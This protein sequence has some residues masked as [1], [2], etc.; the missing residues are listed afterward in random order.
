MK[1][2]GKIF[3]VLLT[4]LL[5]TGCVKESIHMNIKKNGDVELSLIMAFADSAASYMGDMDELK[6][7]YTEKGY[8]VEDYVE[9]DM[10]G[11]KVTRTYKIDDVSSDKEVTV[12]LGEFLEEPNDK[13]VFFQKSG[14]NYKANFT[15]D[16]RSE[17]LDSSSAS[18]YSANIDISYS[19]TL[20]SKPKSH[21]ATKVDGNTLTWD[22]KYGELTKVNYE[23]SL[24]GSNV[25]WIIIAI[26]G[27][28][29]VAI[30]IVVVV[31]GRK[32]KQNPMDG[33][34]MQQQPFDPVY[35]NTMQ[36][37]AVSPTM[38]VSPMPSSEPVMD[39]V[40][41]A[42]TPSVIETSAM[43]MP[44]PEVVEPV[45]ANTTVVETPVEEVPVSSSEPMMDVTPVVENSTV[46]EIVQE[47][48]VETPLVEEV[49][50]TP[51][52]DDINPVLEEVT[53]E[54]PADIQ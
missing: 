7:E 28:A 10:K 1:K 47:P 40:T 50:V 23:F 20:P 19:V 33:N 32:N 51:I 52:E 54:K 35:N 9:D 5:M 14:K 21:N 38:D 13:P 36:S 45:V 12:D 46:T 44:A 26:I 53:E 42:E 39:A 24:N 2:I 15:I 18:M 4:V 29:A 48:A 30:V 34:M 25:L 3:V 37:D 6:E 11:I 49:P 22:V 27:V 41:E 17:D 31:M 16:T 43:E 8:K